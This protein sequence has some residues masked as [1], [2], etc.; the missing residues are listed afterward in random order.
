M[1]TLIIQINNILYVTPRTSEIYY[2]RYLLNKVR[3]PTSYSDIKIVDGIPYDS[4][5]DACYARG[6]VDDDKEYV[7]AINEASQW[8]SGC[9]LRILF[10]TLLMSNS[11]SKPQVVWDVV[12]NYLSAMQNLS[13][14]NNC[15]I[16]VFFKIFTLLRFF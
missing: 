13:F 12:W 11:I 4:F 14:D 7:D 15:K 2:L 6:L 3:G 10:V 5:R 1:M 9:H 16:H 8:A